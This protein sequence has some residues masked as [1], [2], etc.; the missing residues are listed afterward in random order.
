MQLFSSDQYHVPDILFAHST[1][2]IHGMSGAISEAF[3]LKSIKS[4]DQN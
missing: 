2:C 4:A 3:I 1:V